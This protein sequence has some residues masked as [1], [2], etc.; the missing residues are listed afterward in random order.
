MTLR[1]LPMLCGAR[2]AV[3]PVCWSPLAQPPVHLLTPTRR[4]DR[5]FLFASSLVFSLYP[6]KAS[7]FLSTLLR[8]ETV[9]LVRCDIKC[10]SPKGCSLILFVRE[11]QEQ[12]L[13]RRG[14][15]LD[16]GS[17]PG[18]V[19]GGPWGL[20]GLPPTP[21]LDSPRPPP[22]VVVSCGW[23]HCHRVFP[24]GPCGGLTWKTV[25]VGGLWP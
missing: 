25:P 11:E 19:V 4:P 7:Y 13:L 21:T 18:V 20:L 22:R 16:L 12:P 23:A 10:V 2:R 9:H 3:D 1:S 6:I 5:Y 14:P 17:P 24:P 15:S 8:Q